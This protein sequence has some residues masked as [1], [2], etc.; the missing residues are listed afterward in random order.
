MTFATLFFIFSFAGNIQP[1]EGEFLRFIFDGVAVMDDQR[2][3]VL[4]EVETKV[5]IYDENGTQISS[6]GMRGTGPG[7]LNRAKRLWFIDDQLVVEEYDAF[8]FLTT[9][10]KFIKRVDK[11]QFH[12]SFDQI[13]PI[14]DGE[15]LVMVNSADHTPLAR[16]EKVT[17]DVKKQNRLLTWPP[18]KSGSQYVKGKLVQIIHLGEPRGMLV[19]DR[20]S[21]RFALKPSDSNDIRIWNS[22]SQSWE[23]TISLKLKPVQV[24]QAYYDQRF[25]RL[26]KDPSVKYIHEEFISPVERMIFD[27]HGNLQVSVMKGSPENRSWQAFNS[28][29]KAVESSYDLMIGMRV[30]AKFGK[31]LIMTRF[32]EE[33]DA[34]VLDL[35]PFDQVDHYCKANP[36]EL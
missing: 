36:V 1:I 9:T 24:D 5:I 2:F 19:R 35:V 33:N 6:F 15:W 8:S 23:A 4:D 25:S 11:R 29:G 20:F 18:V 10:G 34:W 26:R 16:L 21:P 28:E 7:A 14:P 31:R 12:M 32:D 13:S 27:H 3:A 30:L 22:E 17:A